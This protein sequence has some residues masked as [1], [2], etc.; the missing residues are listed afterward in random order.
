M[1]S[2]ADEI[3]AMLGENSEH[4]DNQVDYARY[5]EEVR[6]RTYSGEV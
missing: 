4:L 5:R 1:T 6:Q 2:M 3:F